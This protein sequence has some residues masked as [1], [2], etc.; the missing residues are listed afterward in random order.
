MSDRA[1]FQDFVLPIV[2]GGVAHVGPPLDAPA[3]ALLAE[4]AIDRPADVLEIERAAAIYGRSLWDRLLPVRLDSAAVAVF[5][6][7]HNLYFLSHPGSQGLAV[8]S[9]RLREVMR[10]S[11]A[12]SRQPA[13]TKESTLLARHC[14]FRHFPNV[15][16][17]DTEVRFWVGSRRFLGQ[18]PP[19]RLLRWGNLRRV[20]R[21]ERHS[22]FL[23]TEL[24]A[25]Q[26]QIVAAI[27][28]YT[29]LSGLMS[30][31]H[32]AP[33]LVAHWVDASRLLQNPRIARL[34]AHHY[35]EPEVF[36]AVG[37]VLA[38]GF[39][40]IVRT[41]K[42]APLGSETRRRAGVAL[43]RWGGLVHYLY[44]CQALV[45]PLDDPL[46]GEEL[47]RSLP[48]VLLALEQVGLL[49]GP[50]QLDEESQLRLAA[51]MSRWADKLGGQAV[52]LGQQVFEALTQAAPVGLLRLAQ[53]S[54][55]STPHTLP[56]PPEPQTAPTP[57]AT[58][59]A[60]GPP[61]EESS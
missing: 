49:A 17:R 19:A 27:F 8:R 56:A 58:L 9:A 33:P 53:P 10:V 51:A 23:S 13:P 1:F 28:A 41:A 3:V 30:I 44:A 4:R 15:L 59:A 16:R 31:E 54:A 50:P 46:D 25:E 52:S 36:A 39:W 18:D 61:A 29:P 35:S 57:P 55:P 14:L 32:G 24:R 34:L 6:A 42:Q 43:R 26:L 20:R 5:A 21:H 38:E 7:L 2:A 12:L 48:A 40:R 11:H 60:P 45:G 47:Q 22:V 37:P